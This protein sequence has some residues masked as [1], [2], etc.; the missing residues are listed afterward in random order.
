MGRLR[1]ELLEEDE[2]RE[3][4]AAVQLDLLTVSTRNCGLHS[5]AGNVDFFKT[6]T[7]TSTRTLVQ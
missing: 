2:L 1:V 4:V 7:F 3:E 5:L 6:M